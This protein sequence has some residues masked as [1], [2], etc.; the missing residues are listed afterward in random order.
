MRVRTLAR[1]RYAATP[2]VLRLYLRLE[3]RWILVWAVSFL[4][5]MY[6]SVI[7]MEQ[8]YPTQE[9][10]QARAGLMSNPAAIMMTGP[11]FALD[12]YTFGAMLA[13][14]LSLW[15]Y[16][17]AAIMSIL[18]AVRRSRGEEET[19]RLEV[20][21]AMPLG[22]HA[23]VAAA[24]L[25]VAI[26]NLIVA[27]AITLAVASVGVADAFAFGISAGLTGILFGAVALLCGQMTEHAKTASGLAFG[28]LGLAV[29]V[30]GF[31][32]VIEPTGSWLSWFSPIAWAQQTR[33]F[34]DLR[35][36]PLL[37]T[38]SAT[39]IIAGLAMALNARR[40]LGAG[41]LPTRSGPASAS[42]FLATPAGLAV[43]LLSGTFVA[44]SAGLFVFAVA[45][46]SLA[47]SIDTLLAD[48][49]AIGEWVAISTDDLTLSFASVIVSLLALG[50]LILGC[51][52]ILQLRRDEREGRL[53]ALLTAGFSRLRIYSAWSAVSSAGAAL[54]MVVMGAGTGLGL[55]LVTG[56]ASWIASLTFASLAYIPAIVLVCAL[57]AAV[58]GTAAPQSL[59]WSLI[60]VI[61]LEV[62]LGDLLSLPGWL[63]N[64][65]PIAHTPLV[66]YEAPAAAPLTV[67]AG[68]AIVLGLLGA[69]S[70]SRR[71]ID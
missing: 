50:P 33:L 10:L 57:S 69:L 11:A 64:L 28:I 66:P 63:R 16:I 2:F 60:A 53:S 68:L 43:R 56:D 20:L 14:E 32:D 65:S 36:W 38:V 34:T 39:V 22:R 51:S 4:T 31:G 21:A 62:Y 44:W 3:R 54:T 15:T 8:A 19:G 37:F 67:M 26:A 29:I 52:A 27:A 46:G 18:L 6:L 12:D 40:D 47:T 59:A 45:F 48:N 17:P 7:A 41:L 35:W 24:A 71:D 55:F 61:A 25:T 1:T 23:P 5:L 70:L 9:A 30:R 13:N 49:P 42:D 58:V